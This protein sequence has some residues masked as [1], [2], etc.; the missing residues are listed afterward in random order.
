MKSL[1][2]PEGRVAPKISVLI[3]TYRGFDAI[4]E[5]LKSLGEQAFPDFEVIVVDHGN[6]PDFYRKLGGLISIMKYPV[7]YQFVPATEY[8]AACW[9]RNEGLKICRGDLVFFMHDRSRLT[10]PDYLERLW[11]ASDEGKRMVG[12]M[13]HVHFSEWNGNGMEEKSIT[14]LGWFAHQD[15]AP[16]HY[17]RQV[18]GFDEQ[19]DGGHGYD[20]IDLFNRI[21]KIGCNFVIDNRLV[22]HKIKGDYKG[23]APD[24]NLNIFVKRWGVW[25]GVF[26]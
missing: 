1:V 9:A 19:F 25:T 15:A 12:T 5:P 26:Q 7:Y 11:K 8:Y 3:A 6:P 14:A 22:S 2:M 20:D 18:G 13:K 16:L 17:L 21:R 23:A 10:G 4:A 24:R